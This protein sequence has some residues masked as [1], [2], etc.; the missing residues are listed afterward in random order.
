MTIRAMAC[1]N[2]ATLH[3]TATSTAIVYWCF[4]VKL[5]A[6]GAPQTKRL[7]CWPRTNGKPPFTG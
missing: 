5:P 4:M 3:F 2:A 1:A 7:W 6:H